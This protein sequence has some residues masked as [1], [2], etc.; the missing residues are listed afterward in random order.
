MMSIMILLKSASSHTHV[1]MLAS[2]KGAAQGFDVKAY[3]VYSPKRDGVRNL[4]IL[5]IAFFLCLITGLKS[6]NPR[7]RASLDANDEPL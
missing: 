3:R 1:N 4:V 6:C 2:T 7:G 5:R